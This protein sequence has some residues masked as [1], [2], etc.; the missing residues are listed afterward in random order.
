MSGK[1]RIVQKAY[2]NLFN[3]H[4]KE[5]FERFFLFLAL[6]GFV[7]HASVVYLIDFEIIKVDS[8]KYPLIQNVISAIYTPFSFI[9][10]YEVLLLVYY[11]PT[12]F[13]NSIAKQY[14][15][16][17]LII[18]RRVFK[19]IAKL[20]VE[21]EDWSD[22]YHLNLL[23]D[24]LGVLA[25]I[26][27]IYAFFKL[28]KNKPKI[29][30]PKNIDDFIF[31][32]KIIALILIPSVIILATYSLVDWLLEIRDF[33]LGVISAIGDVNSV[34]YDKFFNLLILVD[35]TLLVISMFFSTNYNR[36]IRNSGFVVSTILIRLSFH[37]DGWQ[38]TVL[39]L[40]GVAFGVIIQWLYNIISRN[41]VDPAEFEA[42]S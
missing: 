31:I 40:V 9:L 10:I 18:L 34:F 41:E 42:D 6:G 39:I 2:E 35:V 20:D 13:S 21:S 5:Q 7:I 23:V 14:E 1:R 24:M 32:K 27:L 19:D 12:S 37:F 26:A 25:M 30:P 36:L 11:L 17:S 15:I 28:I 8:L 38:N 33:N 4:R 16:V 22:I 29:S 3:E